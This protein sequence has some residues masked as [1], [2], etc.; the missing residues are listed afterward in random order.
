MYDKSKYILQIRCLNHKDLS[1]Y[2]KNKLLSIDPEDITHIVFFKKL[3]VILLN[4]PCYLTELNMKINESKE[5]FVNFWSDFS[6][7]NH[8]YDTRGYILKNCIKLTNNGYIVSIP[9][10]NGKNI[11]LNIDINE[12]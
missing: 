4:L 8:F 3:Y 5:H 12:K 2:L 1:E 9:V 7:N 6:D 11:T 10:K